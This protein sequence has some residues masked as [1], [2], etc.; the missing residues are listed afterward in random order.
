MTV[1]RLQRRLE[2]LHDDEADKSRRHPERRTSAAVARYGREP[3]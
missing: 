3:S 1:L 2:A